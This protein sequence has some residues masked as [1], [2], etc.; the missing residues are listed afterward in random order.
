MSSVNKS[1]RYAPFHL[2]FGR[3][4]RVLPPLVSPPPNPSSDHISAREIIDNLQTDVADARDNLIL[5]KLSQS[6]FANPKRDDG[7]SYEVGE[8][9]MLSTLHRRKEFKSKGKKRVAKFMPRY[10]G[11]YQIVDVHHD[12]STVTLDMPNAPN[13]FPTF[14]ISNIKRWHPNDDKKYPSRTLEQPGPVD[15]NGIDEYLVDSII[16]HRKVGRGHR[17]LVHFTGYGPENDR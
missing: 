2:R 10:D 1:T 7:P 17:Y 9:V 15:V 11:P 5:A 8:K 13:L 16:D 6:H 4:P 3:S 14:H 12:A